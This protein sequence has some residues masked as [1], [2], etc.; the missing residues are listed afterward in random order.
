MFNHK[1]NKCILDSIFSSTMGL[2]IL[3]ELSSVG[4]A[5]IDGI[6]TGV[7]LGGVSMAALGVVNPFFSV[8]SIFTAM[9]AVGTQK[10]CSN[11]LGEGKRE[12]T[13]KAF[14]TAVIM[15]LTASVI[16]TFLLL[17]FSNEIICFFGV[18]DTSSELFV[19]SRNYLRG[20]ICGIPAIIFV[21][22]LTPILQIVG[23][24]RCA[25]I[26]VIIILV[27]DVVLDCCVWLLHGTIY[28]MGIA[29]TISEWLGFGVLICGLI[30]ENDFF[31]FDLKSF[32][33]EYCVSIFKT[34]IPKI[35]RRMCNTA[36]PVVINRYVLLIGGT[37]VMN[38]MSVRSNFE[39]M[40][41]CVGEGLSSAVFLLASFYFG[42]KNSEAIK[43]LWRK[44]LRVISILI[45]A[46][47]A[48]TFIFAEKIASIYVSD[49][50]SSIVYISAALRCL[51]FAL[52]LN[53]L[54]ETL[55]GFIQAAGNIRYANILMIL[56]RFLCITLLVF[57]MGKLFGVSGLFLAYPLSSLLT[58]LLF[59]M[60]ILVKDKKISVQT[61]LCMPKELF[62]LRENSYTKMISSASE[63]IDVSCDVMAFC[64][65]KGI[66]SKRQ[67]YVSLLMEEILMN[68]TTH[69]F[70]KDNKPHSIDIMVMIEDNK[71]TIRIRDN[72]CKFSIKERYMTACYSKENPGKGIGIKIVMQLAQDVE[73]SNSFGTNNVIIK[74]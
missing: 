25:K 41:S 9:V 54:V 29:T 33:L 5:V 64:K 45:L 44:S 8:V 60:V 6:V 71:I 43:Q 4:S 66:D 39:N 53:A 67:Y 72:C 1:N 69:G 40:A 17:F 14:S 28:G 26:A 10:I 31:R 36:R 2:M 20:L 13:S 42:E 19:Q 68:I 30:A 73:Y 12:E 46:I 65:E 21:S 74:L 47:S 51:A 52:P 3:D 22:A 23:K 55:Q 38:A 63:V 59:G 62:R 48:V 18:T 32:R 16:L 50:G 15:A 56:S 35:V 24:K 57:V 49:S 37:L 58:L 61:V 70:S 34:G 7:G 27:A 11:L